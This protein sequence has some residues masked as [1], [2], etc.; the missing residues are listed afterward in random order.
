MA[1][2]MIFRRAG[3]EEEQMR[4]IHFDTEKDGFYGAYWSCG[5]A[6]DCAV[7]T[8]VGDDPE[9]RMARS[10]AKWL[11]GNG[12]NVLTMSP[13]K[14]DYSHHN[15]PVERVEA[16][17]A[18]LKAH[19]NR[20]LG[21]AGASTTGTLALVA[22]SYFPEIT[23]T[24]AMTP[25][26]FVWQGFIQGKKDGCGEWPVEGESLFSYRGK[27]L[28][29][30]PFCYGHPEYWKKMKADAKLGGDI[31]ASRGVFD[32]SEKAHPLTEDE[33]IKVENIR[34]KLLLIGAEDDVLWDTARYIRRM[35]ARLAQKAHSCEVEAAVYVHGTHFVFPEGMLRIM[36]PAGSGLFMRMAF[37]A[38][39]EFPKECRRTRIDIG[40]RMV[41][42][43]GDWKNS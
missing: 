34:G 38:A 9:D 8:M 43:I 32:D 37:R 31:I 17:A 7:I 2:C 4:H 35:E 27:P 14:K 24:V 19:G 23:L 40:R 39:R 26:D 21:I 33:M 12:V 28:P 18:W 15:Y 1:V 16:A 13:G 3:S 25:S 36:L 5:D 10:A 6:A 20:K 41:Q 11:I 29:Y 42:A 22:A 30:M